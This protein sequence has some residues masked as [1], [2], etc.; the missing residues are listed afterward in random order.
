M[1]APRVSVITATYKRSN[2]LRHA[3]ESVLWQTFSDFEMLVVGDG[4]TD[5]SADVVAS[6][7]D[8]RLRWHN[9]ETNAGHQSAP[10]NAGLS[11][12]RGEL[13]AY[14]GH[15]D[16]WF[17]THL[18]GLVDAIDSAHADVAY[19]WTA[20]VFPGPGGMRVISGAN[21]AGTF[22]PDLGVPPSSLLHRRAVFAELGGW[23]DYRTVAGEPEVE[24]LRRAYEAGRKFVA[25][26]RLSVFKFNSAFRRNSYVDKPAHEQA[27]YIRRIREEPDFIERELRDIIRTQMVRHPEDVPRAHDWNS[28]PPG[29]AVKKLRI[30]RGLDPV[31]TR[32]AEDAPFAPFA[33][34]CGSSDADDCLIRGWSQAESNYR[35]SDGPEAAI[36][37]RS[38]GE[39]SLRL[40]VEFVPF[41][42]SGRLERQR[43]KISLRGTVVHAVTVDRADSISLECELPGTLLAPTNEV[44]FRFPDAT[45][46]AA[47]GLSLDVR[48]LAIAV[49]QVSVVPF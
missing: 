44:V 41:L 24:L 11:M 43:V 18:A 49:R 5:D 13:I 7:G 40:R 27:E 1:G 30:L 15:D 17:P 19:S 3:I 9:L 26:P 48:E 37:F 14:L 47:L 29:T 31:E 23:K 38:R 45:S 4:C 35:W 25:H 8:P 10:N 42:A 22:E 16:V 12:A 39:G 2:V 36:A 6:F 46:P 28:A 32:S 20:L 33:V 21:P 34:A